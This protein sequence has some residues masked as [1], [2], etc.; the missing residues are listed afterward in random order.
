MPDIFTLIAAWKKQ[1]LLT[2][3]SSMAVATAVVLILPQ[4]Y[5][6]TTTAV[7]SNPATTDRSIVFNNNLRELYNSLGDATD[8]DIIV[9]TAQLD[10][11]YI[12]VTRQF[13]L[14]TNGDSSAISVLKGARSLKK[15]TKIAKTAFGELQI[16]VLSK[17]KML[18]PQLANALM[19]ELASIHQDLMNRNNKTILAGISHEIE[20]LSRS[21]ET[22]SKSSK[23]SV[24]VSTKN[25]NEQIA[26]YQKIEA[27]FELMNQMERPALHIIE[28]ARL[29]DKPDT[30]KTALILIATAI[31]SFLFALWFA[32]LLDKRQKPGK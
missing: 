4:K 26:A 1:I 32:I 5:L 12:A 29:S 17:D 11:I 25:V 14:T 13:H 15:D 7:P 9:G 24:S 30:P 16:R 10:T 2:V 3:L 27:D 20:R 19:E 18:A 6:A 8:L 22:V 21:H 23:D 28:K 31:A